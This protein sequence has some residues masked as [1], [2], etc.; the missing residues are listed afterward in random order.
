MQTNDIDKL[1]FIGDQVADRMDDGN[2]REVVGFADVESDKASVI[3]KDGGVMG[4]DEINLD[5]IKLNGES[6]AFGLEVDE[7]ITL[8]GWDVETKK[9]DSQVMGREGYMHPCEPPGLNELNFARVM[10]DQ[11]M[12]QVTRQHNQRA[13]DGSVALIISDTE[14]QLLRSQIGATIVRLQ[15]V[16]EE[17]LAMGGAGDK[18]AARELLADVHKAIGDRR[19]T[20]TDNGWKS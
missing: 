19:G 10:S 16:F 18:S 6:I 7:D 8:T 11:I 5:D 3:F 2:L 12:N 9:P 13:D 15:A 20:S 17:E 14:P 4:L 1:I